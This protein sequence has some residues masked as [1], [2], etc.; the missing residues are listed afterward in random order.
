MAWS[1]DSQ[2]EEILLPSGWKGESPRSA[3]DAHRKFGVNILSVRRRTWK[4][5]GGKRKSENF[6]KT[7]NN[8]IPSIVIHIGGLSVIG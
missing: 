4:S 7:G 1:G 8:P 6:S 2:P 5:C 3:D